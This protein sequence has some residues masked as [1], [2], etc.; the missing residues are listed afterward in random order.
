MSSIMRRTIAQN[1]QRKE[2]NTLRFYAN[3]GYVY[4]QKFELPSFDG[5]Y[6]IIGSWVVGDVACGM[7]LRE[8][9]TAVTGNDSHF[10]PHYLYLNGS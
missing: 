7:G 5:M 9:F 10:I 1:L 6:P 3:S 2:A 4:Q 8:D